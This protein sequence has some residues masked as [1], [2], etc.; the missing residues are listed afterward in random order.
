MFPLTCITDKVY[1]N[2]ENMIAA[3]KEEKRQYDIDCYVEEVIEDM[4]ELE[5]RGPALDVLEGRVT[6]R[7]ITTFTFL[8]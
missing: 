7:G 5:L 4:S 2:V 6:E 1:M 3:L 8:V